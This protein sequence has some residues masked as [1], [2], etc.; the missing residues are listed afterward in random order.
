MPSAGNCYHA[1]GE[2]WSGWARRGTEGRSVGGLAKYSRGSWSTDSAYGHPKGPSVFQP[3]PTFHPT[4]LDIFPQ[5]LPAF[6]PPLKRV[7]RAEVIV[8]S[9]DRN[10]LSQEQD[11]I[12]LQRP[13]QL[14]QFPL[15]PSSMPL[16]YHQ[17]F[18]GKRILGLLEKDGNDISR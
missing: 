1:T 5:F 15:S 6:S 8:R 14:I 10:W 12:Q 9:E 18:R 4:W 17:F 11:S 2:P 7:S 3:L 13:S 16:F